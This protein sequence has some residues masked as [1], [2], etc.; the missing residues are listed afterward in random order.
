MTAS[1]PERA[2]SPG[3]HSRE[4]RETRIAF[5]LA[6][7]CGVF[8]LAGFFAQR[9]DSLWLEIALAI[10]SFLLGGVRTL[11]AAALA[12]RKGVLEINFLMIL[13]A[14]VSA[15]LGHWEDGALLLFLFSFSDALEHYAVERTRRGISSLMN[16]RPSTARRLR[17]GVEEIVPIEQLAPDDEIRVRPGERL[18]V[19]GDIVEGEAAMDESVVTGESLPVDKG[20]GAPVFAGTI[21]TNGSLRVRMTRPAAESTIA[22]IVRMVESAQDN[23][24]A[25]QRVIES[26]QT[27]YVAGVLGVSFIAV[28]LAWAVTADFFE[29][30]KRGMVLLVAASPCA[31]VLAS[32]VAVLATVTRAARFG[33]LFKG[34]AHL[35]RLASVEVVALDKTGTVTHGKPR[36]DRVEPIDAMSENELLTLAST[37][38]SRSEHPLAAAIVAETRARGLTW[39]EAVEFEN[40]AGLGVVGRDGGG[41]IA[42]GKPQLFERVGLALPPRLAALAAT[43]HSGST[44]IVCNERGRGGLITLADT[45]REDSAAAIDALRQMEIREILMLTGDR[46]DTAE[47]VGRQVGIRSV[48]AE[49]QPH[50]KLSRIHAIAEKSPIAMVG[51]GVNDAPALAAATVGVAMG[52]AGSDVAL[53]TA[54]VVLM[55]DRLP[56]LVTALRLARR[57]RQTIRMSLCFAFSVIALLVVFTFSAGLP[58]P[59]AVVG[60]EGSTVIVILNGLRLLLFS[61]K[62]IGGG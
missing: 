56:D 31:V 11:I 36:V 48:F 6:I 2:A 41:R 62:P 47:A 40:H 29:G 55:R 25:A 28:F 37:L 38:E 53:E 30:I 35:E 32:P 12:L 1:E 20:P 52:A 21:N 14:V 16:L 9:A 43:P 19:D 45:V 59:L 10:V 51:D 54:D 34:G 17:A 7:G 15:A 23:K 4:Q 46:R 39:P 13:A 57:C 44:V 5:T 50:E 49:L 3:D 60:H 18:P 22:R 27:P 8:G 24:I 61:P 42:A 33:I 58:L 26:W